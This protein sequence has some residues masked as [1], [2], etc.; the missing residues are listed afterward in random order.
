MIPLTWLTNAW[1]KEVNNVPMIARMFKIIMVAIKK[2]IFEHLTKLPTFGK[3]IISYGG[4][5]F[6]IDLDKISTFA[7]SCFSLW[8]TYRILFWGL[9]VT[10][11]RYKHLRASK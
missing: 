7:P 6:K 8:P 5:F 1:P 10:F 3:N 4:K 11:K 9:I 2:I